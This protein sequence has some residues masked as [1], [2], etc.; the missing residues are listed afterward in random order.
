[1]TEQNG[2]MA[3]LLQSGCMLE[4]E[5]LPVRDMDMPRKCLIFRGR[6]LLTNNMRL[7]C[8]HRCHLGGAD[9]L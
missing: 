1:M 8:D 3:A 6:G 2:A 5:R 7:I 4:G 9:K